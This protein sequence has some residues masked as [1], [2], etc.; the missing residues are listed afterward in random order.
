MKTPIILQRLILGPNTFFS[1]LDI[2]FNYNLNIFYGNNG[3]GKSSLLK[4]IKLLTDDKENIDFDFFKHLFRNK[5]DKDKSLI[6]KYEL[7]PMFLKYDHPVIICIHITEDNDI[8]ITSEPP[9]S[10]H[11]IE[12]IIQKLNIQYFN[13]DNIYSLNRED[14]TYLSIAERIWDLFLETTKYFENSLILVNGLDLSLDVA[15]GFQYFQY[16]SDLGQHNQIIMT[17]SRSLGSTSMSEVLYDRRFTTE[18]YLKDPQQKIIYDYFKEDLKTDY[19]KEFQLSIKNIKETLRLKLNVDEKRIKDFIIRI[20]Y[21]NIITAM[22]TYLSDCFIRKIIN[23]KEYI[24]KLLEFIPELKKKK[25]K[26]LKKAY[27][28]FEKLDDNIFD[29]LTR[30]SFHNLSIVQNMYKNILKIEFPEK[31][32]KIYRAISIRHDIIHR[33]GKTKEGEEFPITKEDLDDLIKIISKFIKKI[34]LHVREI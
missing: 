14:L 7:N 1:D 34:E 30:F 3:T 32:G 24:P 13:F 15:H 17:S 11:E 12:Q 2:Q 27:E 28:W 26:D 31:L 9:F 10:S 25:F 23:N 33:N 19:Y 20:L 8:E 16:L 5:K 21:A 4:I 29:V 6:F 22:E 18:F